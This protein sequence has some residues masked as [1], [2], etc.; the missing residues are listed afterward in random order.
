LYT[1]WLRASALLAGW[2]AGMV[3]GSA[4]AWQQGLKPV[5]TF[6]FGDAHYG[7]YIGLIALALNFVVSI[8][9]TPVAARLKRE[10]RPDRTQAIDYQDALPD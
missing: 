5:Y 2:L 10:R 7:I 8:L 9:M 1:R 4:L 6:V 3:L